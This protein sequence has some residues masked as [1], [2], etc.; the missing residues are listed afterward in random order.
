MGLTPRET[1]VVTT[2]EFEALRGRLTALE[3]TGE[4]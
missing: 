3:L 4:Q 1:N 2:P